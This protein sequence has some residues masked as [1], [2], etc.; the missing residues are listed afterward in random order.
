MDVNNQMSRADNGGVSSRE[1]YIIHF[2]SARDLPI[3]CSLICAFRTKDLV[4][5]GHRLKNGMM[6][7]IV[8]LVN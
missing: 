2:L 4:A 3:R 6:E 7:L 1:Y 5:I 8:T